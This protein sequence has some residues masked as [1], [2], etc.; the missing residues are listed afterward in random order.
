M[1]MPSPSLL[2]Y[3]GIVDAGQLS[4]G[5]RSHGEREQSGCILRALYTRRKY[6]WMRRMG[7]GGGSWHSTEAMKSLNCDCRCFP[8][9]QIGISSLSWVG[10]RMLASRL[11]EL[12]DAFQARVVAS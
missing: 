4:G 10:L 12:A 5:S 3:S 8:C 1:A 11:A 2:A 6:S 9:G 7:T